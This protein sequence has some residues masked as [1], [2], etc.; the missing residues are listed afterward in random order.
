MQTAAVT[1]VAGD[2][3]SFEVLLV[4]VHRHLNHVAGDFLFRLFIAREIPLV[5]AGNVAEV[6]MDAEGGSHHVH[7]ALQLGGRHALNS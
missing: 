5:L 3:G 2:G 7:R 4:E 1:T 6:A